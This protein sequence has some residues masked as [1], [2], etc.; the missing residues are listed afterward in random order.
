MWYQVTFI[1]DEGNQKLSKKHI[2][3][4][5]LDQVISPTL[6]VHKDNIERWRIHRRYGPHK[7]KFEAYCSNTT[8]GQ[9]I[10]GDL[11]NHQFSNDLLSNNV[12]TRVTP[13]TGGSNLID[14]CDPNWPQEFKVVWPEFAEQQSK[15][16]LDL[17]EIIR[18]GSP[19]SPIIQSIQSMPFNDIIKFYESIQE[20]VDKLWLNFGSH[21]FIHHMHSFFAYSPFV[22]SLEVMNYDI[23]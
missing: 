22:S 16:Q 3:L 19:K 14:I 2:D 18:I 7:L 1:I 20:T 4:A 8:D 17:T 9:T 21:T 11:V 12:A 13:S 10:Q 5:I 23:R 6:S 15:M